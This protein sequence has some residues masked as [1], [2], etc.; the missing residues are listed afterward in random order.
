MKSCRDV[1]FCLL[2]VLVVVV[3]AA[4]RKSMSDENRP[5]LT[6]ILTGVFEVCHFVL[7][8]FTGVN[9][10]DHPQLCTDNAPQQTYAP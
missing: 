2:L 7:P 1:L 10:S 9:L 5:P 4:V 8:G 6:E 3:V